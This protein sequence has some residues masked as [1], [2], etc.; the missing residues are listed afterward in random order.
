LP[1]DVPPYH[2]VRKELERR[3]GTRRFLP[4]SFYLEV[5]II[6]RDLRVNEAIRARE[7][8][9]IDVGG[10][11]VGIVPLKEALRIAGER[12]VDLVEVAPNARP[13]VCRIMDYGKFKYEQ[14]KREREARK[15]QKSVEIKEVKM[16]PKIEDHDFEVKARN[17]ERFLEDNNKVK[18]TI[19]FRGREIVHADLARNLLVRLAARVE[20]LAVVEREPRVEGRNM[21]MILSPKPDRGRGDRS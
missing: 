16:R 11:Q 7:V 8:R 21:T 19:M 18:A 12:G 2:G 13:A 5:T 6:A 9:L 14:S 4:G 3:V 1:A 15:R 20:D 17:A 10:E